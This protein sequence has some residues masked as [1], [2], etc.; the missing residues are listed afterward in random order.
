MLDAASSGIAALGAL[1]L[2]LAMKMTRINMEQMTVARMS[3]NPKKA[4]SD[5]L[6]TQY[7]KSWSRAQL[8]NTEYAPMLAVLMLLIKCK[9]DRAERKLC[10]AERLSIYGAVAGTFVFVF[11]VAN[12]VH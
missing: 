7:Y 1:E 11:A 6:K 2:L 12:Q 10:A 9:A 3:S 4:A 5:F 8:N